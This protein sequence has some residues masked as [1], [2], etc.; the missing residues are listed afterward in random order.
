MKPATQAII[1]NVFDRA[2]LDAS[3]GAEL[4]LSGV[5]LLEDIYLPYGF[6]WV[7]SSLG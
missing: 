1:E 3:F 7:F 5:A 6:L 4:E 2:M